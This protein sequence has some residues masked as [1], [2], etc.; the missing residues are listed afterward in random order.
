MS[1]AV[2]SIWH[3]HYL[4]VSLRTA[5]HLVY[6][7]VLYF[8][9]YNKLVLNLFCYCVRNPSIWGGTV[10]QSRATWN[11]VIAY[12]Q[13][14]SVMYAMCDIPF[15]TDFGW[16]WRIIGGHDTV[17]SIITCWIPTY[18]GAALTVHRDAPHLFMARYDTHTL[19]WRVRGAHKEL[20]RSCLLVLD[21]S[22]AWRDI[23]SYV[24]CAVLPM[25]PSSI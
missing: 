16:S 17:W 25:L 18:A 8:I 19:L 11:V 24:R 7:A 9:T 20:G 3:R 22:G 5:N 2:L 10:R 21:C 1:G 12:E 13:T 15:M 4:S 14:H 23:G 6:I